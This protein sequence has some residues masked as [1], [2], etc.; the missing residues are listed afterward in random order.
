MATKM[1]IEPIFEADFQ[2]Y[3]FGFRPK[4]NAHQAVARIRK[5]SRKCFWVVD[6]DIQGYLDNIN[7]SKLMALLEQRISD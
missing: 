5:V 1:V 3:S 7:Q 6:V 2:A 4:R